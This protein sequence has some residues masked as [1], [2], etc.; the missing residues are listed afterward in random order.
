MVEREIHGTHN[1]DGLGREDVRELG[2]EVVADTESLDVVHFA[3]NALRIY[4]E[5]RQTVVVQVKLDRSDFIS[6]CLGDGIDAVVGKVQKAEFLHLRYC[7][8]VEFLHIAYIH[9]ENLYSL[10]S[11]ALG[12]EID[13][14]FRLSIEQLRIVAHIQDLKFLEMAY[15]IR[16]MEHL[17]AVVNLEFEQGFHILHRR[18]KICEFSVGYVQ[19]LH[20]GEVPDFVRKGGESVAEFAAG[21]VHRGYCRSIF[22]RKNLSLGV[23]VVERD[24]RYADIVLLKGSGHRLGKLMERVNHRQ[25]LLVALQTGG[26]SPAALHCRVILDYVQVVVRA[27]VEFH[28]FAQLTDGRREVSPEAEVADIDKG[29]AAIGMQLYARLVSPEVRRFVEIPVGAVRPVFSKI[30]PVL[31]VERLPD[32]LEGSIILHILGR[33]VHSHRHFH[34]GCLIVPYFKYGILLR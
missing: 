11:R 19:A 30:I 26:T 5:G 12:E 17:R 8:A 3:E 9:I 14:L 34:L 33:L 31:P 23:T 6:E 13:D 29:H 10:G 21:D 22:H 27:Q 2:E 1:V 18:R 28:K 16:A 15:D 7:S 20:L 4:R 25:I 24:F 32:F